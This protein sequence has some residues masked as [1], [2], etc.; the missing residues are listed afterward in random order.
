MKRKRPLLITGILVGALLALGPLWGMLGTVLGMTRAFTV[1]NGNGISDPNA[2]SGA[3]GTTLFATACGL[4][5][6]PVG[7]ALLILCIVMLGK[8]KGQQP[9]PP[10][11]PGS[12]PSG[13]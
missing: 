5:A 3:I 4:L 10:I 7:I 2:L 8:N 1:L 12:A 11:P 9:P 6:C 13:S